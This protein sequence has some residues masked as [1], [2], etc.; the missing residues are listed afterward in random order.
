[1]S[2]QSALQ[3][4]TS[5]HDV[6]LASRVRHD[7]VRADALLGPFSNVGPQGWRQ[8]TG[9][10]HYAAALDGWFLPPVTADQALAGQSCAR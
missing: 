4:F 9:K 5:Y 2:A 1:M 7:L 8:S 3:V 10:D 6:F